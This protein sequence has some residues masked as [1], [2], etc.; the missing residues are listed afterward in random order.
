MRR[1]LLSLLVVLMA[2]DVAAG[3]F[4]IGTGGVG[5][6]VSVTTLAFQPKVVIFSW[7]GRTAVGQAEADAKPGMGFALS[8]TSRRA[9]TAQSD[10]GV[11]TSAADNV[12]YDDA[13]IALLTTAGAVDGKADFDAFLSNGFRVIIDDVFVASY[14]I[15]YFAIGGADLTDTAIVTETAPGATGDQDITTIGIALNTGANDKCA[16]FLRAGGLSVNTIDTDCMF[17]IGVAAGDTPV[18]AVF[19]DYDADAAANAITN[20]YCRAGECLA[21]TSETGGTDIATRRASVTA[22]LSNGL[23]L[24]W[25]EI[26]GGDFAILV[27]KG[28]QYFVGDIL[29]QTGTSNTAETGVGFQPKALMLASH[30]KAQSTVDTPQAVNER[31]IGFAVSATERCSMGMLS[32]DSPTT[33][34]IGTAQHSDN[35]YSNQSTA[36]AIV[37]EGLMDLV[38]M[39]SDGFTFVMDDA[40]PAQ[41]FVWYLAMGDAPTVASPVFEFRVPQYA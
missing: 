35:M 38:S 6:T 15:N 27:L 37:I 40:D 30:N 12:L 13:C 25:A 11:G 2:L 28:G 18:N 36:T 1:L 16:I 21:L 17:G 4:N 31:T 19:S 26:G 10:H 7:S 9:S 14:L 41:A 5:T 23:R 3:T 39:D 8:T 29:S 22:W 33:T 24:N 20:S 34:D 32:K